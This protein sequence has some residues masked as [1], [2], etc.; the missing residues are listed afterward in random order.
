MPAPVP[1]CT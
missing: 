1:T